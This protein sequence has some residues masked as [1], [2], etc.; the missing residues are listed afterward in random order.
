MP[1]AVNAEITLPLLIPSS[2]ATSRVVS[3]RFTYNS[4]SRS[5]PAFGSGRSMPAAAN[6]R[7]AVGW[8]TP[9]SRAIDVGV[10]P[11]ATNPRRVSGSTGQALWESR[12]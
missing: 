11:A 2:A 1:A 12:R 3:C 9:C 8:D 4:V 5:V 6:H 7:V 10:A